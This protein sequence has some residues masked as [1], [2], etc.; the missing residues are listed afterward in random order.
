MPTIKRVDLLILE[1]AH[2]EQDLTGE[3]LT[4]PWGRR[5]SASGV[6]S[7]TD[8]SFMEHIVVNVVFMFI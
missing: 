2:L 6:E 3:R 7:S 8:D 1:E 5:F 4:E